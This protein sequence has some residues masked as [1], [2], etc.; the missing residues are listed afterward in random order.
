LTPR[1]RID[2]RGIVA[3][4]LAVRGLRD[5][6]TPRSLEGLSAAVDGH[7]SPWSI[8]VVAQVDPAI[9]ER[10]H[11]AAGHRRLLIGT[12]SRAPSNALVTARRLGVELLDGDMLERLPSP[13]GASLAQDTEVR[14]LRSRG[15]ALFDRGEYE[16]ALAAYRAAR[17]AEPSDLRL[18]LAVAAALYK[19]RRFTEELA[20]Y[21]GCLRQGLD[22][23]RIWLNKGATLHRL[24]RLE[25]A[26]AAYDEVLRRLP[27]N[28]R[29]RNNRGAALLAL[30]RRD[31]AVESL[32]LAQYFEPSMEE[33]RRNL[34]KARAS[35]RAALPPNPSLQAFSEG[36]PAPEGAA[37]ASLLA[38]VGRTKDA[39]LAWEE[40]V[41]ADPPRGWLGMSRALRVL[42]HENE[43]ARCLDR[44]ASAGE[45]AAVFAKAL[46]FAAAGAAEDA[47]AALSPYSGF[48]SQAW[49]ASR[50][51]ASGDQAK[52]LLHLD[53]AV[54]ANPSADLA[55]NLKGTLELRRGNYRNAQEAFERAVAGNR[56][57]GL[58][59]NNRGVALFRMGDVDR[60]R[61]AFERAT[62]LESHCAEFWV[63]LGIA[64]L[65]S[66]AVK[67][68]QQ[69]F[70]RAS[71]LSPEW[72]A[73]LVELAALRRGRGD[74]RGAKRLLSRAVALGWR[75]PRTEARVSPAAAAA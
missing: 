10:L 20:E 37:R 40:V 65:R 21:E 31:E 5:A 35:N 3:R 52:A 38:S 47:E 50:A 51:L 29:A 44:A 49:R 71:S 25:E 34:A 22:L 53:A 46:S 7:G 57:L 62:S 41:G 15:D 73:P 32:R 14:D 16:A 24:G 4:L 18:R 43:A 36:P 64:R 2:D 67:S 58:A 33:V 6:G 28:G 39:L 23:P 63:N 72:P 70:E 59:E 56:G 48:R 30:G 27:E 66:G 68:A 13:T 26:V 55:W 12:P 74:K 54:A 17:D 11:T 8:A 9:V 60:A 45:P 19:L 69:A 1:P 42:G 61:K 75:R